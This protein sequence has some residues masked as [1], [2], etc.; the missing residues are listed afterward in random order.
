MPGLDRT[1]PRGL[2][3]RTGRGFGL[4]QPAYLPLRRGLGLRRGRRYRGGR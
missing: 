3:P 2:G 4:C 1:G